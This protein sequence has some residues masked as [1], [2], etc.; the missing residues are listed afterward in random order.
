MN[1]ILERLE[2]L[3]KDGLHPEAVRVQFHPGGSIMTVVFGDWVDA[4]EGVTGLPETPR[5]VQ[6]FGWERYPDD[7][8]RLPEA[9]WEEVERWVH[10]TAWRSKAYDWARNHYDAILQEHELGGLYGRFWEL[11]LEMQPRHLSWLFK[12]NAWL[13]PRLPEFIQKRGLKKREGDVP[14]YRIREIKPNNQF[15]F[16]MGHK[17][18]RLGGEHE[19]AIWI[20][21]TRFEA[22]VDASG[23]VAEIIDGRFSTFLS[24]LDRASVKQLLSAAG[25][26]ARAMNGVGPLHADAGRFVADISRNLKRADIRDLE[27]GER[28]FMLLD[29]E[30]VAELHGLSE[31]ILG[32]MGR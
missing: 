18:N 29:V 3:V 21:G 24:P 31:A 13:H 19:E 9:S 32:A 30:D 5:G 28:I 8:S 14:Q 23:K 22:I 25:A 16:T 4:R 1:P 15:V 2:S 11:G 26:A 6:A 10:E 27:G 7:W 20:P 12:P 17:N